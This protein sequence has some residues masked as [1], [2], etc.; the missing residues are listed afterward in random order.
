MF[1]SETN[2]HIG[3]E[4]IGKNSKGEAEFKFLVHSRELRPRDLINK[5]C[6]CGFLMHS[7]YTVSWEEISFL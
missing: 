5:S 6:L 7:T 2:K 1:V 3:K 4:K